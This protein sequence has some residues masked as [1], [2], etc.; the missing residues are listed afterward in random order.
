MRKIAYL[1]A[2]MMIAF[3]SRAGAEG[4][5]SLKEVGKSMTEIG[6]AMDEE[7]ETFNA[8]KAA[9][10]SGDIRKGLSK[11]EIKS[12]YGEPVIANEDYATRRE[13][14]AYKPSDSTF[15]EGIRIYIFFDDKGKLDEIRTSS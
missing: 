15:F 2:A 9:I 1:A 4:L 12:K 14:W 5:G 6:K 10:D 3:S 7:T 8:V 13:K 11:A